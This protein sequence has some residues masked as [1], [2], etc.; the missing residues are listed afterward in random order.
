MGKRGL[1][2]KLKKIHSKTVKGEFTPCIVPKIIAYDQNEKKGWRFVCGKGKE[3]RVGFE[4]DPD[5]EKEIWDITLLKEKQTPLSIQ[6]AETTV[7]KEEDPFSLGVYE[8]KYPFS[9]EKEGKRMPISAKQSPPL[10]I[11][12]NYP[13]STDRCNP[14]EEGKYESYIRYI[15]VSL[16]RANEV[17]FCIESDLLK[18][19][20][21]KDLITAYRRIT[22][23][24]NVLFHSCVEYQTQ[25]DELNKYILTWKTFKLFKVTRRKCWGCY[26]NVEKKNYESQYWDSFN[27]ICKRC[28]LRRICAYC[29]KFGFKKKRKI[30]Q[31][32]DIVVAFLK[33]EKTKVV[34]IDKCTGCGAMH[35][36]SVDCQKKDWKRHKE[37]CRGDWYATRCKA[38]TTI[39]NAKPYTPDDR[40][41]FLCG[42]EKEAKDLCILFMGYFAAVGCMR[43]YAVTLNILGF[44]PNSRFFL[45]FIAFEKIQH[46]KPGQT[47]KDLPPSSR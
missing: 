6:K 11:P 27:P 17:Q 46:L 35:Y 32:D 40:H 36:C 3:I 38:L 41:C 1:K 25:L 7:I 5:I 20:Y 31:T 26:D 28:S 22:Y 10:E 42:E 30:F 9:V 24:W 21:R 4:L 29:C 8:N 15:E 39:S 2:K 43:C 19:P 37:E 33:E 47:L 44:T 13:L 16:N 23:I 18:N 12:F 14:R 45:R 34:L